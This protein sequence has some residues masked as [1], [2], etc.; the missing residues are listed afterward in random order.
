MIKAL[1]KLFNTINK[2]NPLPSC[3]NLNHLYCFSTSQNA[4]QNGTVLDSIR[5]QDTVIYVAKGDLTEES[6]DAIVNAA[7]G[8]LI[9]GGGVAAAIAR[10]GGS[11]FQAD[12]NQLIKEHGSIPTGSAVA[13]KVS[14]SSLLKCKYV[15]HAIGPIYQD[16]KQ[17]EE[18]LLSHCIQKSL[19]IADS[20][21]P[22]LTSI[23]FPAVSSGIFGFPKDLCAKVFFTTLFN[24][25]NLAHNDTHIKHVRLVN[26]D[27]ITVNIFLKE[28]ENFRKKLKE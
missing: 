15:I 3:L 1:P 14:S 16:G 6:T 7:N 26:F 27:D 13:Q 18:N 22:P 8:R 25:F 5:V 28:L 23:S 4:Y 2:R 20:L 10:K 24:H 12:S 21:Q 17:N 11:E 19:R 9:H